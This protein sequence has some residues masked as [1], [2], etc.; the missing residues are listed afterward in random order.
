MNLRVIEG[1]KKVKPDYRRIYHRVYFDCLRKAADIAVG[2]DGLDSNKLK[3]VVL[4]GIKMINTIDRKIKDPETCEAIY[5]LSQFIINTIGHLTPR[6]FENIF[7]ITKEY[8]GDKYGFKD[9]FYTKKYLIE[10]GE[11]SLIRDK[12]DDLLWEYQNNEVRTFN[13]NFLSNI[14]DMRRFEG[15]KGVMEE[16]LEDKG[17]ATYTLF[18]DERGQKHLKNNDTNEVVKV[19]KPK[20]RYLNLVKEKSPIPDQEN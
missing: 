6:Q 9:Y 2:I 5:S 12:V 14:S 8:D 1:I 19:K 16:F 13:V 11:D 3:Q 15:K 10:I 7:P 20:P 17:I 4:F 18:E